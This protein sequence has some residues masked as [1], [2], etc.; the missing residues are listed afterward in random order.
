MLGVR[1]TFDGT[2]L[3]RQR[4][5][6]LLVALLAV[7]AGCQFGPGD[8]T[9]TGTETTTSTATTHTAT[10]T[11]TSTSAPAAGVSFTHGPAADA[12]PDGLGARVPPGELA[13]LP[14]LYRQHYRAVRNGT[15]RFQ[16][17]L[18]GDPGDN[19]TAR[20]TVTAIRGSP[21]TLDRRVLT[22]TGQ[23]VDGEVQRRVL[24]AYRVDGP[25]LFYRSTSI[26]GETLERTSG[27]VQGASYEESV[28]TIGGATPPWPIRDLVVRLAAA[29]RFG[30]GEQVVVNGTTLTRYR[31]RG[32]DRDAYDVLGLTDHDAPRSVLPD[33]SLYSEDPYPT[34]TGTIH[35]DDTG[36]IRRV[37]LTLRKPEVDEEIPTTVRVT[38]RLA[39]L[40]GV[41]D[42]PLWVER[43]PRLRI[44]GLDAGGTVVAVE[45]RGGPPVEVSGT[46]EAGNRT[47]MTVFPFFT[48]E[49]VEPGETLYVYAEPDDDGNEVEL[50]STI[51]TRP[52]GPFVALPVRRFD[53]SGGPTDARD[54]AP[55]EHEFHVGVNGSTEPS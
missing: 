42:P 14:R 29:G 46:L 39:E 20:L 48:L 34:Y 54:G 10:A 53:L 36:R 55:L 40:D 4:V 3:A 51:G 13:D 19:R 27:L 5:A 33:W 17:R 11:P 8:P 41:M 22:T 38:A 9:P 25:T 2:V 43:T 21:G 49:S 32:L 44:R 45:H 37:N 7:S 35:V 52:D 30:P 15:Y 31:A 6:A 12:P 24:A 26:G 23:V 28:G 50:R 18:V 1:A 16:G 47:S